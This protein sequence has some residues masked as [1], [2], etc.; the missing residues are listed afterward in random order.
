MFGIGDQT[1]LC[2]KNTQQENFSAIIIKSIRLKEFNHLKTLLP[3]DSDKSDL[4]D[5]CLKSFP[6]NYP[7][8][9]SVLIPILNRKF[10]TYQKWMLEKV[11]P[12]FQKLLLGMKHKEI[13]PNSIKLIKSDFN[14][15]WRDCLFQGKIILYIETNKG[16]FEIHFP[17]CIK[18]KRTWLIGDRF[19]FRNKE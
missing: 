4:I 11:E 7:T 12:S 19:Y 9:D 16:G 13:N 17:E 18:S 3:M 14:A 10:D 15:D 5:S 2:Q 1:G 6:E 8:P